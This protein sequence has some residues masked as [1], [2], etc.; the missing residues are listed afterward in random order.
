MNRAITAASLSVLFCFSGI[1][2]SQE[3]QKLDFPSDTRAS[4][5][6][7]LSLLDKVQWSEPGITRDALKGKTTIV[8][9]YATWCP[10]CNKWSGRMFDQL[11]DAVK[12]RPVVMLAVNADKTP[13]SARKYVAERNFNAP[14]IIHGYHPTIDKIL[15]FQSN[16]FHYVQI[17]PSGKVD[18]RGSAGMQDQGGNFGLPERIQKDQNLGEFLFISPDMP[19]SLQALLWPCELGRMSDTALRAAQKKL[20]PD[21]NDAI[22]TAIDSFLDTRLDRIRQNYKGSISERLNAYASAGILSKM[23]KSSEQSKKAKQVTAFMEKDKQF[24]QELAAQKAYQSALERIA[25]KPQRRI[26]LLKAISRRFKG[27]HFGD[28]ASEAIDSAANK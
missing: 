17:G 16:L 26:P 4:S 19:D 21:Q 18:R 24:K 22:E 5:V 10:L 14:N 12:G 6:D 15:G 8:L 13:R 23:F 28:M 9:V 11:K 25:A 1:A 3:G 27:T 7:V 20:P 2:W